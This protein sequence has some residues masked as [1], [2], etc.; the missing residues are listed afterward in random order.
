MVV[1]PVCED[2]SQFKSKDDHKICSVY[3]L[4]FSFVST[5]IV[6]DVICRVMP[7]V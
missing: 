4:A 7:G 2:T 5:I 3:R 6:C 1:D